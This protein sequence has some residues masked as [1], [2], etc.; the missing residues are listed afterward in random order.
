MSDTEIIRAYLERDLLKNVVPLKMLAAYPQGIEAFH[1]RV[2]EDEG[3][4]LLLE[5]AVSPF[6]AATYPTSDK[7][8]LL[9][10]DSPTVTKALCQHI[11]TDQ[12]L[13]FK[14]CRE[15]DKEIIARQMPVQRKTAYISYTAPTSTKSK[16]GHHDHVDVSRQWDA[17][18]MPLYAQNSYTPEEVTGYFASDVIADHAWNFAI[19][20]D[21]EPVCACLAYKNYKNVWEIGAL[22]TLPDYRR[23]GLAQQ[24]VE[25]AVSTLLAYNL[26]PR[27]QIREDNEAS[28]QLAEKLNLE[29]FL[30]TTHYFHHVQ[31]P[32]AINIAVPEDSADLV[33]ILKAAFTIEAERYHKFD[34][35]PLQETVANFAASFAELTI[36]K[37]EQNGRIVGSVNTRCEDDTC[38]IGRLVVDPLLHNQG[39]GKQLMLRAQADNPQVNRFELYTGYRSHNNIRFY[40][41]LGYK[42]Y[43]TKMFEPDFG[44]VY[45]EKIQ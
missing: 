19:F 28:Y 24:V 10:S 34:I 23:Q 44:M 15:A 26:I 31:T 20:A 35:P 5:T 1:A 30:T 14:L 21:N 38:Y 40:E 33:R 18:L 2:D 45:M 29:R 7:I 17:R 22:Y 8:V 42:I 6:D 4:L 39:I 11:P 27:Y 37:A 25:T 9:A 3:V 32:V 16:W 36:Y 41:K 13:V 43:D 12:N